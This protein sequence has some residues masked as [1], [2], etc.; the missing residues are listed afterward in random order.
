MM[1]LGGL[2]LSSGFGLD[3]SSTDPGNVSS[4]PGLSMSCATSSS[5]F[6]MTSSGSVFGTVPLGC[7][8]NWSTNGTLSGRLC[9][10][11]SLLEEVVWPRPR[12]CGRVLIG[13]TGSPLM[14]ASDIYWRVFLEDG[15]YE[16]SGE[17]LIAVYRE[18]CST[19][20]TVVGC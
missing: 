5:G 8:T 2:T 6:T 1:G 18:A 3:N 15:G 10:V 9:W 19:A 16:W 12:V 13:E 4:L 20:N 17:R 7:G 11:G 14:A